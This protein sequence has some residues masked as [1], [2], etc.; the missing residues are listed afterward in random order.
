MGA[1]S[2][3]SNDLL[4]T[5][6]AAAADS[7]CTCAAVGDASIVLN[8]TWMGAWGGRRE[9]F[10]L[11]ERMTAMGVGTRRGAAAASRLIDAFP[12]RCLNTKWLSSDF[13]VTAKW[14]SRY[15][16]FTCCGCCCCSC[17]CCSYCFRCF[18]GVCWL[19]YMATCCISC[20]R[21]GWP[22]KQ[23]RRGER[24]TTKIAPSETDPQYLLLLLTM[25][26]PLAPSSAPPSY[27]VWFSFS[28]FVILLPLLLFFFFFVYLCCGALLK[29]QAASL[30][31][32]SSSSCCFSCFCWYILPIV[33]IVALVV[34]VVVQL[35]CKTERNKQMWVSCSNRQTVHSSTS[36]II[37][38][39]VNK[40]D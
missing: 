38:L 23:Q 3:W 10:Q 20:A 21:R 31:S 32:F 28:F 36:S 11:L 35:N 6:T 12:V 5:A 33:P 22:Q 14:P 37:Y 2:C 27:C 26:P 8:V 30:L 24:F 29:V 7:C 34:V 15:C 1:S 25:P 17:C 39:I 18:V 13:Q 4:A 40:N 19:L 9:V 16:R